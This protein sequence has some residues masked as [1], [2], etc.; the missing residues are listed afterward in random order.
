MAGGDGGSGGGGREGSQCVA[1]HC[2]AQALTDD[3]LPEFRRRSRVKSYWVLCYDTVERSG[4]DLAGRS[5]WPHSSVACGLP[6][7]CCA[8]TNDSSGMTMKSIEWPEET[9]A[10]AAAAAAEKAISVWPA[11]AWRRR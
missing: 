4:E 8:I 2:L 9:A 6:M 7:P 1:G 3:C 10:A 5:H 11:I